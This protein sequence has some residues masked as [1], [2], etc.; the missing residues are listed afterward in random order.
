MCVC[1]HNILSAQHLA[2]F[3]CNVAALGRNGGDSEALVSLFK[4]TCPCRCCGRVRHS[5]RIRAETPPRRGFDGISCVQLWRRCFSENVAYF[6]LKAA[7]SVRSLCLCGVFPSP[8]CKCVILHSLTS[9]SF[10]S[11]DDCAFH[12]AAVQLFG[13]RRLNQRHAG[14]QSVAWA[15]WWIFFTFLLSISGPVC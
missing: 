14:T 4:A 3:A 15:S 9:L 8:R 2:F 1:D 10:C 13:W 11:R 7:S 12:S 6:T 5:E